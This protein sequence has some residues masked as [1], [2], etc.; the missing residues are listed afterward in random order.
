MFMVPTSGPSGQVHKTIVLP[1]LC[2]CRGGKHSSLSQ[3][4][5]NS[6]LQCQLWMW[7]V[8]EAGLCATPQHTRDIPPPQV[9]QGLEEG[10]IRQQEEKEEEEGC[11]PCQEELQPQGAQG[12]RP[13]L[14]PHLLW[15]R[16]FTSVLVF[17]Q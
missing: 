17:S 10:L 7:K 8:L 16:Y 15:H 1:L 12:W 6:A 3:P 11:E 4:H 2:I 5:H 9:P 14:G 13:A